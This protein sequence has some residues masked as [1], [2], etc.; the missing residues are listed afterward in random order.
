MGTKAIRDSMETTLGMK[1]KAKFNHLTGGVVGMYACCY[2]FRPRASLAKIKGT[3][4]N[5]LFFLKGLDRLNKE[6][7]LSYIVKNGRILRFF[8]KTVLDRDQYILLKLKETEFINSEPE[9]K[10][11]SSWSKLPDRRL[12]LERYIENLQR[13]TL[14]K[15]DISLM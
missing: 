13:K 7:D 4:R 1:S 12:L 10:K 3:G 11:M 8:L 15:Q 6:A 9:V 2:F 5:T 14:G